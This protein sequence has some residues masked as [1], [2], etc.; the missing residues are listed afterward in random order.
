MDLH[1][2]NIL[3]DLEKDNFQAYLLTKF[4]N[5]EYISNYKPTSF[6]FCVIKE[7]PIIYTSKMDLEIA[8]RDSKIEIREYE[9]FEAMVGELKK[10]GIKNLAIEPSL[11]YSTYEKFKDDFSIESKTY[12]DKQRMIKT[13][14]EIVNIEKATEI[15]QKSF[16][17]LDIFNNEFYP[18]NI[19]INKVIDICLSKQK[20]LQFIDPVYVYKISMVSNQKTLDDLETVLI[21]RK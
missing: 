12:I 11:A 21:N 19:D 9:S 17:E 20:F 6:A 4:T 2:N 5:I 10:E 14:E 8:N 16:L 3:N 15:A 7:N 18:K 13:P 1:I